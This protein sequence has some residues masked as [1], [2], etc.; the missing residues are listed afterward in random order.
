MKSSLSIVA[1]RF[2]GVDESIGDG[3]E[4]ESSQSARA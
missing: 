1:H 4:K 3:A 2:H